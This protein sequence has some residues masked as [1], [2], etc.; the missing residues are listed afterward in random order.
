MRNACQCRSGG[1]SVDDHAGATREYR[2]IRLYSRIQLYRLGALAQ[3]ASRDDQGREASGRPTPPFAG[4]RARPCYYA[5]A[6]YARPRP[7]AC[8]RARGH[9]VDLF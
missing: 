7:R 3:R 9:A 4:A 8:A 1:S 2:C 6:H 5:H